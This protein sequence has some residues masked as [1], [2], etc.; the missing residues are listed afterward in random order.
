MHRKLGRHLWGHFERLVPTTAHGGR[1]GRKFALAIADEWL[2][3]RPCYVLD[4]V[5]EPQ[6]AYFAKKEVS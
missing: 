6:Q 2:K 3:E 5:T 4:N 1:Q